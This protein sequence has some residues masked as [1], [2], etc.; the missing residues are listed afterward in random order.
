MPRHRERGRPEAVHDVTGG[1]VRLRPRERRLAAVRIPVT[2]NAGGELRFRARRGLRIVAARAVHGG[3]PAPERVARAL[4]VERLAIHAAEPLRVVAAGAETAEASRVRVRVACGAVVV[5]NRTEQRDG[6][7]AQGRGDRGAR[8]AMALEARD[9][10]VVPRERVAGLP[11]VEGE[12]GL[13]ARGGVTAR[14]RLPR[15]V[16]VLVLV[17]GRALALQPEIAPGAVLALRDPDRLRALER[18][19]VAVAALDLRVLAL[20]GPAR[21]AMVET[22]GRPLVE[23]DQGGIAARV[24]RVALDALAPPLPRVEPALLSRQPGDLAVACEALL[25]HRAPPGTVAAR[26]LRHAVELFVRARERSRRD[27]RED[28]GEDG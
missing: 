15:R 24:L 1:A 2:G 22:L 5:R 25:A 27:S 28:R 8:L 16:P 4:V 21:P 10:R 6:G 18:G 17:A 26:A 12:R 14:A 11:V 9:A 23:A 19:L 3:V 7:R 13:P 20:D